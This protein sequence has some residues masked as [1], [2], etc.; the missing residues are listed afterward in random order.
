MDV[1]EA[2]KKL[3]DRTC[4]RGFLKINNSPS[5]VKG[6]LYKRGTE[7]FFLQNEHEGG[8]PSNTFEWKYG[9]LINPNE[10]D[11][12]AN[13]WEYEKTDYN[14]MEIEYICINN[15]W[16]NLN[17]YLG[18]SILITK[19]SPSGSSGLRCG[20]VCIITEAHPGY[21]IVDDRWSLYLTHL[22]RDFHFLKRPKVTIKSNE[23]PIQVGQWIQTLED[24]IA[25][26]KGAYLRI[27][28]I[29]RSIVETMTQQGSIIMIHKPSICDQALA[30][31]KIMPIEWEPG[32]FTSG[33]KF[34][35]NTFKQ[36]LGPSTPPPLPKKAG[37]ETRP[38]TKETS[39]ASRPILCFK[40]E[41]E[42]KTEMPVK[43]HKPILLRSQE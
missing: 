2:S 40:P 41:I 8:A 33:T 11:Y 30:K 26:N 29:D 15:D 37:I 5:P 16:D 31:F 13:S 7:L 27:K 36:I 3:D 38:Q 9:W 19:D 43:H 35:P 39:S 20:A 32:T 22:N 21:F 18:R 12:E 34:D 17:Q 24:D 6:A 25:F 14:P 23:I 4:V 42:E 28:K 10:N 1:F